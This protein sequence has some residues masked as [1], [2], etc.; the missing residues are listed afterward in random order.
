RYK[1]TLFLLKP[2]ARTL[3]S[4][5]TVPLPLID[6]R[7][8]MPKVSVGLPSGSTVLIPGRVIVPNLA[9]TI[10]LSIKVPAVGE[11]GP[12]VMKLFSEKLAGF[13]A[14]FTGSCVMALAATAW[15]P[16]R[17]AL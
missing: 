7:K 15:N 16:T 13:Q 17:S 6:F 1:K 4:I 8:P 3:P 12:V 11:V 5:V 2:G 14:E 9:A 10:R